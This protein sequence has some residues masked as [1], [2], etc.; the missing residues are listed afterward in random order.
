[1]NPEDARFLASLVSNNKEFLASSSSGILK[2][3]SPN[4]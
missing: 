4:G 1:L 2:E 3:N